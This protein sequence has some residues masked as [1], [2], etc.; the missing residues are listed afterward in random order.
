MK[1]II[2]LFLII[3][4]YPQ[5]SFTEDETY[6]YQVDNC[7]KKN[8]K[9]GELAWKQCVDKIHYSSDY[10][11][12][13]GSANFIYEKD[14]PVELFEI[15]PKDSSKT[16]KKTKEVNSPDDKIGYFKAEIQNYNENFLISK[17]ENVEIRIPGKDNI[18]VSTDFIWVWPSD[19][20]DKCSIFWHLNP[21]GG[22]LIFDLTE[23][24]LKRSDVEGKKWTW[25]SGKTYGVNII[26]P[27][28]SFFSTKTRLSDIEKCI[29][30]NT[31]QKYSGFKN[32][33]E[34]ACKYALA[35]EL[36]SRFVKQ[37]RD[38]LY[39]L[40]IDGKPENYFRYKILNDISN[41]FKITRFE[42]NI[43]YKGKDCKG[44]Y[45]FKEKVDIE[46]GSSFNSEK[47]I[48]E[49]FFIYS[50]T[51]CKEVSSLKADLKMWGFYY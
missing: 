51:P 25:G 27:P 19:N 21:T 34:R 30:R 36:E 5:I 24:N 32:E 39:K 10:K 38:L 42:I 37:E 49:N 2:I 13:S 43:N 7:E 6:L 8:K 46:P 44:N 31:R 33:F 4:F 17:I 40:N 20:K 28:N 15:I 41:D 47:K 11:S 26:K 29:N 12:F 50:N 35:T 9:M 45:W 22:C 23:F 18:L 14:K 16:K 1:K 48:E 3:L